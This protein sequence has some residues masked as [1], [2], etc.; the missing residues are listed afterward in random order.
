MNFFSSY[1]NGNGFMKSLGD[2]GYLV[3]CNNEKRKAR[4]R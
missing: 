1:A 4:V 2:L 3:G